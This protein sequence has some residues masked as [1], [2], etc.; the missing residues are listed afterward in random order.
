MLDDAPK[1]ITA[2]CRPRRQGSRQLMGGLGTVLVFIAGPLFVR[3]STGA[4]AA[5]V[6]VK[7]VVFD[8]RHTEYQWQL[9]DLAPGLPADWTEYNFLVLE[10]RASSSER[11]Q[12]EI[13]T[14]EAKVAKRIQPFQNTW[15]RAAV[16]LEFFR[17]PARG[18]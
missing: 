4:A 16:P 13:I 17:R 11:F 14:P 1:G 18:V 7:R 10:M 12:L 9:S 3:P 5:G 2:H 8:A 6:P 15:V